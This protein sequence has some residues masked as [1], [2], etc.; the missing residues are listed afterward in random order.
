M[1]VKCRWTGVRALSAAVLVLAA[2]GCHDDGPAAFA[3]SPLSGVNEVP[4]NDSGANGSVTFELDGSIVHYTVDLHAISGVM[5]VYVD[6]GVP[7]EI[8]PERVILYRGPTTGAVDGVLVEGTF[9]AA[10]VGGMSFSTL[11]DEMRS[12][13]AYVNV[14]STRFRSGDVRAQIRHVP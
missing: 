3:S 7:G 8:G 13:A 5:K 6:S 9:S 4:P 10:D 1:W 12:G 11:V 2:V 14:C